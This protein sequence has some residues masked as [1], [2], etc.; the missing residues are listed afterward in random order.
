MICME[1][2]R[3]VLPPASSS[4]ETSHETV[5]TKRLPDKQ[6]PMRPDSPPLAHFEAAAATGPGGDKPH[7]HS[8]AH[9]SESVPHL[10]GKPIVD[11]YYWLSRDLISYKHSGVFPVALYLLAT[12]HHTLHAQCLITVAAL[13]PPLN[14][15]V[16]T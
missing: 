1:E 10:C 8:R 11:G 5:Q 3:S 6:A 13:H 9:K 2:Y 4:P 7:G 15:S 12:T 14:T 16:S